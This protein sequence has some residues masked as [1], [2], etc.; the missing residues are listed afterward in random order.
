M[1][2]WAWRYTGHQ[3]L[4][5]GIPGRVT[6]PSKTGGLA[7]VRF[8]VDG[9]DIAPEVIAPPYYVRW[10]TNAIPNGSHTLTIIARDNAGNSDHCDSHADQRQQLGQTWP[11]GTISPTGRERTRRTSRA[12]VRRRLSI[13]NL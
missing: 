11:T 4:S 8:L 13:S 2:C 6:F 5:V 3:Y 12:P 10:K 7:G 1:G 9:L